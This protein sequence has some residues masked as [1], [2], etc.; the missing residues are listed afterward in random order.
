[1]ERPPLLWVHVHLYSPRKYANLCRKKSFQC[2]FM[3]KSLRM[4]LLPDPAGEAYGTSQTLLR[5]NRG[6]A[7]PS[8]R[9]PSRVSAFGPNFRPEFKLPLPTLISGYAYSE[10]SASYQRCKFCHKHNKSL[11]RKCFLC[12]HVP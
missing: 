6:L 10:N 7:A 4:G 12:H 5:V 3:T 2:F 11:G 8:L 1:M 9:T